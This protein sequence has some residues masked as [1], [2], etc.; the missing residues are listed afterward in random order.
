MK[1][2]YRLVWAF[3]ALG[4]VRTIMFLIL[5]P[6]TIPVHFNAA[7]EAARMGS[8]YEYIM[9]PFITAGMGTIFLLLAKQARNKNTPHQLWCGPRRNN[10]STCIQPGDCVFADSPGFSIPI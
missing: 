9:L 10:S 3:I 5:A 8:K 1:Y 4:F 2:F 6:D 7:W